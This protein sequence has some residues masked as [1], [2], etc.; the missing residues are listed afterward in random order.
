M[1]GF[2]HQLYRKNKTAQQV[3]HSRNALLLS[4][5]LNNLQN[6]SYA[7]LSNRHQ[8]VAIQAHAFTHNKRNR[9]EC[10]VLSFLISSAKNRDFV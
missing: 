5:T 7:V 3:T 9:D 4:N 10:E 1:F 6:D 8:Y 2:H